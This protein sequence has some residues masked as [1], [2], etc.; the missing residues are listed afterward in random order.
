MLDDKGR[1]RCPRCKALALKESSNFNDI[2]YRCSSED[3]ETLFFMKN[4]RG[5]PK[6]YQPGEKRKLTY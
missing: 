5:V 3:C 1:V 2:T 6:P 4:D